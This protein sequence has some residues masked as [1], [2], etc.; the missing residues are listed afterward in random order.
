MLQQ[1]CRDFVAHYVF[2]DLHEDEEKEDEGEGWSSKQ[3]LLFSALIFQCIIARLIVVENT[4]LWFFDFF[5]VLD[6]NTE[7]E[8]DKLNSKRVVLAGFCKFIAYG[9]F[10]MKFVIGVFSHLITVS[11]LHMTMTCKF[12]YN[13]M[14]IRSGFYSSR[15]CWRRLLWE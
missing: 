8:V 15:K 2:S 10:E 9:V 13:K 4:G 12:F 7:H 3:K 14:R 5:Y 1:H 6:D 11:A